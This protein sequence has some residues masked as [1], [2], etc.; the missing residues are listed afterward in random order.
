VRGVP[1]YFAAAWHHDHADEPTF[2]WHELDNDRNETRKVEEFRDGV[3][4]RAD[5]AHPDGETQLSYEPMPALDFIEAQAEFTVHPLT[6]EEFQQV[7][8]TAR[9]ER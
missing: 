7:W 2:M 6:A 5:A 1:S 3:R 4:L 9:Y 8:E